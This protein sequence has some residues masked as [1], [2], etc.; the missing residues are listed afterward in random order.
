MGNPGLKYR[1]T[2]HNVGQWVFEGLEQHFKLSWSKKEKLFSE[3]CHISFKEKTKNV[4]LVKP[5]VFMNESGKCVFNFCS[6]FKLNP[7]E[8]LVIH[9]ELDLMPGVAKFKFGGRSAGHRGIESIQSML[10][11]QNFWRLRIGIGHPKSLGLSQNVSNFVLSSPK[12]EDKDLIDLSFS[13]FSKNI[14]I[15]FNKKIEQVNNLLISDSL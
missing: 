9:D 12:K 7:L 15:F 11:T 1:N 5:T 6:F 8:I 4:I 13:M 2:R 14:S 10:G 3:F